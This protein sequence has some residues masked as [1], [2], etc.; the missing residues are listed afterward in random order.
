MVS[1]EAFARGAIVYGEGVL[2]DFVFRI[3]VVFIYLMN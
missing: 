1:L 3:R 2:I